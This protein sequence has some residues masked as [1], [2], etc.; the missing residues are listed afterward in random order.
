VSPTELPGGLVSG[1][2]LQT[3]RH[4]GRAILLRQAGHLLIEDDLG[5]PDSN[6]GE[7]IGREAAI[8]RFHGGMI[9]MLREP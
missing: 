8:I 3:A 1:Q 7:G 9:R 5:P 4:K 2:A 6:F